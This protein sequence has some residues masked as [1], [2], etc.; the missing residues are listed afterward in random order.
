L[1]TAGLSNLDRTCAE[2]LLKEAAEMS[3]SDAETLCQVL[4]AA[5]VES[6]PLNQT[7]ST[8][9]TGA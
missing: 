5:L 3:C 1:Y 9:Y 6:T 7:Q 8:L 4:D 2:V